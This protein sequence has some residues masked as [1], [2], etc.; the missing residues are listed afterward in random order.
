MQPS[1]YG[2]EINACCRISM[3]TAFVAVIVRCMDD[4]G[5][6]IAANHHSFASMPIFW[7]PFY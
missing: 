2:E 1:R 5:S 4:D 6:K 3:T 7:D